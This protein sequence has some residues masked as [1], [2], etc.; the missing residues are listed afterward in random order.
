MDVFYDAVE[1]IAKTASAFDL[2]RTGEVW[3]HFQEDF[4][5]FVDAVHTLLMVKISLS[6][7]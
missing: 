1:F 7:N 3:A 4:H 5:S 2:P 6:L